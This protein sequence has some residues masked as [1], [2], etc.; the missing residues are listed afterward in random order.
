M[1]SM[2]VKAFFGFLAV[3][4]VTITLVVIAF[5]LASGNTVDDQ[6]QITLADHINRDSI[7]RYEVRGRI[8]ANEEHY[9]Y[10]ITVSQ[11]A[12]NIE[13]YSGYNQEIIASKT[14]PNN[15]ASYREFVYALDRSGF[16]SVNDELL[17][18]ICASGRLNI[19]EFNQQDKLLA[20]Q[21]NTACGD[22]SLRNFDPSWLF[23]AQIPDF[24]DI[25]SGIRL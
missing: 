25:T 17:T 20:R 8:V 2:N 12:R 10:R 22:R 5:A 23:E 4:L 18:G 3:V 24:Q 21:W 14:Y 1:Y 15:E 11:N 19:Y 6:N 7:A 13:V 16:D 9:G